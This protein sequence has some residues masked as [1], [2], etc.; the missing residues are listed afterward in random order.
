MPFFR[1]CGEPSDAT[2]SCGALITAIDDGTFLLNSGLV[3]MGQGIHTAFV[4]IAAE[5]L[6]VSYEAINFVKLD[7]HYSEDCSIT[8]ASRSTVIASQSVYK[9][10][11]TLRGMLLETAVSLLGGKL[12]AEQ[13]DIKNSICF[14]IANPDNSIPLANVCAARYWKGKQMSAYHW[15]E[16]PLD[17]L[18]PQTGQGKGFLTYCYGVAV[19]ETEV[20]TGTGFVDVKKITVAHDLGT[21]I[22]PDTVLGQI[23]GGIAM[24]LGYATTEDIAAE[25]GDI[26]N[27]NFDN[28]IFPAAI[29]MPEMEVYLY[30][31]NDPSGTFGSK[32]IAEPATEA[33]AAAIA[34]AIAN[35]TGR[36]IQDLPVDLES[37]VIGK[38][39][40]PGKKR[41]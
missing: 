11:K 40:T 39:L 41:Q 9:A 36:Y 24:G 29:D 19:A 35:A 31:C 12:S 5:A 4:Q 33:V 38:R 25:N 3:E 34:S 16:C 18:D 13:M 37:V 15:H 2:N 28:Y 27:E 17:G 21:V 23:Y 30:E 20:D 6:G 14:E 8:V 1:G 22:N 32:S 10:A 7:T 26:H